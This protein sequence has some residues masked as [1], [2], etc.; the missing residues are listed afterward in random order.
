MFVGGEFFK[1]IDGFFSDFVTH[2][3]QPSGAEA[4][5]PSSARGGRAGTGKHFFRR[6]LYFPEEFFKAFPTG[7][8]QIDG[9]ASRE[10]ESIGL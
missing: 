9:I 1:T 8:G 2:N 3:S 7:I 10:Q 5:L 4:D 6:S